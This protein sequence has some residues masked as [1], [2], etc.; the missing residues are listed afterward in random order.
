MV[1]QVGAQGAQSQS[2]SQS[3]GTGTGIGTPPPAPAATQP[4]NTTGYSFFGG[5]AATGAPNS[6]ANGNPLISQDQTSLS[7]YYMGQVGGYGITPGALPGGLSNASTI[8]QA[9]QDLYSLSISQLMQL[10]NMLLQAG[11]YENA[12]GSVLSDAGAI[13]YGQADNQTWLALGRALVQAATS[14]Q[15]VMGLLQN[16]IASGIGVS[17]QTTLPQAVIGGG[18]TY[19]IDLTQPGAVNE[20]TNSIFQAALGRNATPDE[21]NSVLAAVNAGEIAQGQAR[22]TAGETASQQKYQAQVNQRNIA[23]QFQKNPKTA[24]GPVPTG[25]FANI[26]QWAAQLLGYMQLPVTSQNVAFL[27]SMSRQLGGSTNNPLNATNPMAASTVGANGAAIYQNA[28]QALEATAQELLNAKFA[29]LYDALQ[30]GNPGSYQGVGN[31]VSVWSNGSLKGVTPNAADNQAAQNA[32][33]AQQQTTQRGAAPVTGKEASLNL[34]AGVANPTGGGA[35]AVGVPA[36]GVAPGTA[37]TPASAVNQGQQPPNPG[38]VYL[39]PVTATIGTPLS[40]EQAAYAQATTG[41]NRFS[42]AENNYLKA[43]LAAMNMIKAG[44]PTG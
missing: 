35:P 30:T 19:E 33:S 36:P 38:D 6:A 7:Q 20:V 40:P 9:L 32:V 27:V 15:S 42:F 21:I 16:R 4:S 25:P 28:S 3:A 41:P 39:N 5:N 17:Q 44:G 14:G 11:F 12:D 43:F 8:G 22:V 18:N 31:A 34:G 29:G 26:A 2:Q 13:A 1:D 10:Q 37:T 24:L 23:Y